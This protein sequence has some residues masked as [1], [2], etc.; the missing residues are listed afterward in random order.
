MVGEIR[1]VKINIS[2]IMA[3]VKVY[4]LPPINPVKTF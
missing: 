4:K 2:S 3:N 1:M